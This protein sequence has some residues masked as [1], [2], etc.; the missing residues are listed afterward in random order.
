VGNHIAP[1]GG[2]SIVRQLQHILDKVNRASDGHGVSTSPSKRFTIHG[3]Q[4]DAPEE[5]S[6]LADARI[7]HDPFALRPASVST[8]RRWTRAVDGRRS[9]KNERAAGGTD[10]SLIA[11]K[12]DQRANSQ[13]RTCHSL[14][15][16]NVERDLLPSFSCDPALSPA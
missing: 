10:G 15:W 13:P 11:A 9:S 6:G 5:L 16:H 14:D 4:R 8:I 2:P 3:R 7:G 12:S 1:E